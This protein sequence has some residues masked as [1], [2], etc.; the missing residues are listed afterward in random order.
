MIIGALRNR[1]SIQSKTKTADGIGGFTT[2]WTTVSTV[3]AN[4]KP[5]S[6]R[7]INIADRIAPN[8]SHVITIRHR[9]GVSE[10]Q[11][12]VFDSRTFAINGI[13]TN[14]EGKAKYLVLFCNE[15]DAP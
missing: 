12:I 11:R 13:T 10:Q 8:T 5:M 1:I 4:V 2:S 9:D 15:G 14:E 3:W 7:E 6:A